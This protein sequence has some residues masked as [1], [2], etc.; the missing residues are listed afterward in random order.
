MAILVER[1][2]RMEDTAGYSGSEVAQYVR[3]QPILDLKD[4]ISRLERSEQDLFNNI[5]E[6]DVSDEKSGNGSKMVFPEKMQDWVVSQFRNDGESPQDVLERMSDQ[7][8]IE[9]VNRWTKEGGIYNPERLKRPKDFTKKDT[10]RE[11]IEAARKNCAFCDPL[12]RTPVT[13]KIGRLTDKYGTTC[14]NATKF[15]KF[16]ELILGPHNPFEQTRESFRSQ[17]RKALEIARQVNKIDP[18]AQFFQFG[19]NRGPDAAASLFHQHTQVII[20][21]S[22]MHF[23]DAERWHEASVRYRQEKGRDL[24]SDWFLAHEMVGLGLKLPDSDGD[25]LVVAS[26]TPKKEYGVVIVGPRMADPFSLSEK[27]IDTFW[28]VEDF[29]VGELGIEQFNAALYMPPFSRSDDYWRDFRPM[30]TF[31]RR[32]KSDMGIMEGAG[33]AVLSVDPKSFAPRMFS[34]LTKKA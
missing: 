31:V 17:V 29:M 22:S 12:N 6:V 15:A 1:E 13:E 32:T 19:E 4:S 20:S 33:T 24:T 14:A 18:L 28:G 11:D 27:S 7:R 23:A 5:F 10:Y 8:V 16:H 30:F 34:H 21:V 25:I 9:V 26:L 2:V 3:E